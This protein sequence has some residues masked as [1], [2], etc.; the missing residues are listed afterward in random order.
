MNFKKLQRVQAT[1]DENI[2]L[3]TNLKEC[4]NT[5]FN[6]STVALS[7]SISDIAKTSE[8]F[9]P[10]KSSIGKIDGGRY[11]KSVSN[12]SGEEDGLLYDAFLDT[13]VSP[14]KA[15]HLNLLEKCLD[16]FHQ[17]LSIANQ[18]E[19]K[20]H[21]IGN[22]FRIEK[23]DDTL[24]Q[25]FLFMQNEIGDLKLH[26]FFASDFDMIVDVFFIYIDQLGITSDELEQAYY[27]ETSHLVVMEG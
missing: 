14:E 7:V 23:N 27:A 10:Q 15:Y 18:A 21:V 5:T 3:D 26:S 12:S 6:K 17:L 24:E 8:H 9:H 22:Y 1:L 20:L 16:A 4:P 13:Y 11:Y 2:Y 19:H 25:N